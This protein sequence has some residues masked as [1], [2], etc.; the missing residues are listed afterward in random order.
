MTSY[1]EL[2]SADYINQLIEYVENILGVAFRKTGAGK[3]NAY[4]PF[5]KDSNDSFRVYVNDK[6][7]VRFHCFGACDADWDVYDIIQKAHNC[8]FGEAQQVL[9]TYLD[10]KAEYYKKAPESALSVTRVES[11]IEAEQE[12]SSFSVVAPDEVD[13]GYASVIETSSKFYHEILA[14]GGE[15]VEPI[16]GYLKKRGVSEEHIR[17]YQVGYSPS[18]KSEPSEGKALLKEHLPQFEESY[19]V[20]REFYNAGVFRLLDDETAKG[21]LYYRQFVDNSMGIYGSYGDFFAGKITFPIKNM[22]GQYV[23]IMGRRPDNRG[24]FR[25]MK[26]RLD[27]GDINPKSWLYGIDKAYPYIAKYKTVILVEGIFD[28]FAVLNSFQDTT[29][30]IVV[31]TL[32]KNLS[33]EALALLQG[34]GVRHFVV[35]YDCDAAGMK[36]IQAIAKEIG[37][38]QVT[39]L[40]GMKEGQDPADHLSGLNVGIDG[41]SMAHLLKGAE[42]AQALTEKPVHV[43]VIATANH[44]DG[45]MVFSPAGMPSSKDSEV[46]QEKPKEYAY[47]AEHLLSMLSYNHSNKSGLEAQI[48]SLIEYIESRSLASDKERV[49]TLP[50]NFVEERKYL[51]LGTAL[52]LWLKIAIEQQSKK[53][54]VVMTDAALGNALNTSRKTISSYKRELKDAG[55]L[56]MKLHGKQQRLSVKYFVQ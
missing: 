16:Y 40:G 51:D 34:L 24:G 48:N 53:R 47:D 15:S 21:H 49:F 3:Y 1:K 30:P 50:Y 37:R 23:G 10:E 14:S 52:I 54:R 36:G 38:S 7:I 43:E 9:A 41:F 32:G 2:K 27:G 33:N 20:F 56:N 13:E 26:Q 25:W 6:E 12:E 8:S 18:F 46:L 11:H 44:G 22:K 19:L 39:Y 4:C 31:S 35:A 55:Y 17:G 29:K 45:H 42:K 5:H 28:Y